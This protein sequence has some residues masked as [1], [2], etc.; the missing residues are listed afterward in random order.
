MYT[1]IKFVPYNFLLDVKLNGVIEKNY[2]NLISFRIYIAK[3]KCLLFFMQNVTCVAVQLKTINPFFL[4]VWSLLFS[5]LLQKV[6]NS[7]YYNAAWW[8]IH[9]HTKRYPHINHSLVDIQ[10]QD[11]IKK[12]QFSSTHNVLA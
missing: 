9:M 2:K 5:I 12:Q 10:T 1:Y 8:Y 7:F 3:T 4:H 6:F 11:V